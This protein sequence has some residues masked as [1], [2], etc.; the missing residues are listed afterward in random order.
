MKVVV[1]VARAGVF[2]RASGHQ[3]GPP[4]LGQELDTDSLGLCLALLQHQRP[5]LLV[6]HVHVRGRHHVVERASGPP[7]VVVRTVEAVAHAHQR[8]PPGPVSVVDDPLGLL[9]LPLLFVV[10]RFLLGCDGRF[11]DRDSS[12]Q[13]A[14]LARAE[15]GIHLALQSPHGLEKGLPP[16]IDAGADL[17]QRSAHGL[18]LVV[19]LPIGDGRQGFDALCDLFQLRGVDGPVV[20]G[21]KGLRRALGLG[22]RGQYFGGD[23]LLDG[24]R[25]GAHLVGLVFHVRA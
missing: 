9:P 10:P 3:V 15:V 18:V 2:G 22:H 6:H 14:I 12:L 5:A 19:G 16:R 23:V 17:Y 11:H 21:L 1:Q 25:I 7:D 13:A 8:L 4:L 20:G 24:V